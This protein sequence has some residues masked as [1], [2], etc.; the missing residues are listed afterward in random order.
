M[1]F[2]GLRIAG[3]RSGP[4]VLGEPLDVFDDQLH[5]GRLNQVSTSPDGGELRLED[6]RTTDLKRLGT[7]R[8]A[9]LI[10]VEVLSFFVDRYPAISA[11]GIVLSA[12]IEAFEAQEEGATRLAGARARMLQSVGVQ[13]IQ[14]MPR[15]HPR[16]AAHFVVGGVWL[17]NRD[18]ARLLT[19]VLQEERA[20]YAGRL[21]AVPPAEPLPRSMLSRLLSKDRG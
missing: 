8:T 21:A 15:P 10:V 9:R 20:V 14:V 18:N 11:I 13:D 19:D 6:F 17:Y 1:T 7:W 3:P 4:Y 16:H 2:Q 5:L 12:D